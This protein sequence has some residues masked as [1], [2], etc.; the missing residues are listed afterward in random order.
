MENSSVRVLDTLKRVNTFGAAHTA[1]FPA[2]SIGAAQFSKIAA[3][4]TQTS[5]LGSTQV[6]G[7]NTA[8]SAAMDK[9]AARVSLRAD[10]S[11]INHAAHSLALMGTA[12]LDGKFQMPRGSGDQPLLNAARAFATDAAAFSAQF[13]QLGLPAAFI[14]TLNADIT[15]LEAANTTKTGGVETK[16]G[17]TGGIAQTIHDATTA[18]HILDTIVK[19]T[20]VNNPTALAAWI[21]A[22]HVERP[23]Q[24]TKATAPTAKPAGS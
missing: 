19:N 7:K 24:K 16:A 22:S 8:H 2:G 17:A 1:D 23:P 10:L 3:A 6:S 20:Y 14:T 13:I 21:T 4:V 15:A 12:G 5:N 18:L 9:A 11:A